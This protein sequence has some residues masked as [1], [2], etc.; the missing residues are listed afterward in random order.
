MAAGYVTNYGNVENDGLSWDTPKRSIQ[1][2]IDAGL[3][4]ISGVG[5]FLRLYLLAQYRLRLTRLDF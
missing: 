1:S 4:P 3:S 5:F 2:A